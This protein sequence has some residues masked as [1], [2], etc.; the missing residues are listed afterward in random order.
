MVGEQPPLGYPFR[1]T[2]AHGPSVGASSGEEPIEEGYARETQARLHEGTKVFKGRRKWAELRTGRTP[3]P[4]PPSSTAAPLPG[5][6]SPPSCLLPPH[7]L[8][9]KGP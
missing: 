5:R 7:N 1:R 4:P 3:P 6:S 8:E 2:R 9:T